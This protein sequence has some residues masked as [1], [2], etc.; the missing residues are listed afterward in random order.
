M[1]GF[2]GSSIVQKQSRTVRSVTRCFRESA[3]TPAERTMSSGIAWPP[4]SAAT[5]TQPKRLKAP[6]ILMALLALVVQSLKVVLGRV[7]E[8]LV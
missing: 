8:A 1:I 2:L 6:P 3:E 5:S 7:D 4:F